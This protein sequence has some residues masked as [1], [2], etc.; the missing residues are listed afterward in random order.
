MNR[1]TT[2]FNR[3]NSFNLYSTGLP[4]DYLYTKTTRV[5]SYKDFINKELVLF[6]NMDN[7]RS[8]P[9]L[10]DGLKPGSRKVGIETS[11]DGRNLKD[12]KKQY[13]SA[14][15]GKLSAF[16]VSPNKYVVNNSFLAAYYKNSWQYWGRYII[17]DWL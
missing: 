9:S 17:I 11:L 5:V 10:V 15:G 12:W 13:H 4:E 2:T 1:P 16:A 14:S 7:E 3:W 8:I 6:S